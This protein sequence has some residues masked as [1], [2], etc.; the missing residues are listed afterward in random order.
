MA[1]GIL[2]MYNWL[3]QW[4]RRDGPLSIEDIHQTFANMLLRGI[5]V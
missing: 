4:Y 5:E 3:I 1:Y 2:G